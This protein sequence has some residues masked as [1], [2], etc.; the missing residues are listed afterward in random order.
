[1]RWE[2]LPAPCDV[3][4]VSIKYRGRGGRGERGG[5]K[6]MGIIPPAWLDRWELLVFQKL[7][8]PAPQGGPRPA[9]IPAI[10]MG[11]VSAGALTGVGR[12]GWRVRGAQL[13]GMFCKELFSWNWEH[14]RPSI[15]AICMGWVSAGALSGVRRGVER[16]G[17]PK[18]SLLWI[19]FIVPYWEIKSTIA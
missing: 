18:R 15:P 1:M 17:A 12:G 16:S 8:W 13:S 6:P 10:C 4:L 19:K 7:I 5:G 3:P 14:Y 2:K 9:P 11:W